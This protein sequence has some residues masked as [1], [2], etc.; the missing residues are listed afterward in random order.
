MK[1]DAIGDP[2][3]I[4]TILPRPLSDRRAVGRTRIKEKS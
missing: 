2:T 4:R 3:P 1:A